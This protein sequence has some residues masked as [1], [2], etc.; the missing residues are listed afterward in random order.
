MW[1]PTVKIAT[2]MRA[3]VEMLLRPS[4]RYVQSSTTE[5]WKPPCGP[6]ACIVCIFSVGFK[7]S[8]EKHGA[9][10]KQQTL[11]SAL[12]RNLLDEESSKSTGKGL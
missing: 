4:R 1:D 3:A 8:K 7:L 5:G 2:E 9:N 10:T 6:H 11:C 12:V